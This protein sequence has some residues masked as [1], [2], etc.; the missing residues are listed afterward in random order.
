MHCQHCKNRVEE[1]VNDIK[2]IAGKVDLKKG[3]LTV[4]YAEDVA[5]EIIKARIERAGYE[6]ISKWKTAI[7]NTFRLLE[8]IRLLSFRKSHSLFWRL[9][10]PDF[11]M[12]YNPTLYN[13]GNCCDNCWHIS[14]GVRNNKVKNWCQH[15]KS[16]AC[17]YGC[18]CLVG[19]TMHLACLHR[20]KLNQGKYTDIYDRSLQE[21]GGSMAYGF[22]QKAHA[23]YCVAS[24]A[25]RYIKIFKD[26]IVWVG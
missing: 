3:E 24:E 16:C 26:W 21:N 17:Y 14:V 12:P 4:S 2:G 11:E 9:Y 15:L 5:D 20:S 25:L 7:K 6:V 10:F 19:N 13:I 1:V 18:I 22:I 23:E 8:S